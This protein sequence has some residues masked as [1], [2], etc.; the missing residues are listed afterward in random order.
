VP[1]AVLDLQYRDVRHS[2]KSKP[3]GF[4]Y[5]RLGAGITT[6]EPPSWAPSWRLRGSKAR[7]AQQVRYNR[8]EPSRKLTGLLILQRQGDRFG[9]DSSSKLIAKRIR[10]HLLIR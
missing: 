3:W 5:L 10:R 1:S 6:A 7:R 8:R 2:K 4:G 9:R